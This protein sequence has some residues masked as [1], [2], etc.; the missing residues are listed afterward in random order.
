MALASIHSLT[1]WR[2]TLQ[3]HKSK[4]G[5]VVSGAYPHL[6]TPAGI[7]SHPP[8]VRPGI[9]V[10]HSKPYQAPIAAESV[11]IGQMASMVVGQLLDGQ[12]ALRKDI[13]FVFCTQCTL[14]Q[15]I[16]GSA[17]LRVCHE[18]H[19]SKATLART[20]GQMGTA[21]IPTAM[22][23]AAAHIAGQKLETLAC[24]TASDKW[25]A[26]F[27]RQFSGL[28]TY[29]DAAA[30]CF[31]GQ[32]QELGIA[33]IEAVNTVLRPYEGN[34][35]TTPA[36]VLQ[37]HL[38]DLAAECA[39]AVHG[40]AAVDALIGDQYI[41]RFEHAVSKRTGIPLLMGHGLEPEGPQ[42]HLSSASPL[43][44]ISRALEV[45]QGRSKAM[46]LVV[47]TVSLSG[48]AGAMRL[49]LL[50]GSRLQGSTW[51]STV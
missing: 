15:Q 18:H 9:Q 31:V 44:A 50:P 37:D 10:L 35:W 2:P 1:T 40:N 38:I 24:I 42:I 51:R 16:L 43:F 26:P 39:G 7:A 49:L 12:S 4:L 6:L 13:G 32:P 5:T 41:G 14:D 33:T 8:Y 3:W 17:C 27:V 36:Q 20:F 23:L 47:W 34:L 45:N 22:Q 21:C 46:R 25:V 19:L 11:R 28:V 48:F 29:G 30:A